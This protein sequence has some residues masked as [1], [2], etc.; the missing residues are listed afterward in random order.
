VR[1]KLLGAAIAALFTSENASAAM[2]VEYAFTGTGTAD[3]RDQRQAGD[4]FTR[5]N[6][7]FIGRILVDLSTSSQLL[8][9]GLSYGPEEVSGGVDANS[10]F[11]NYA[12]S[13]HH[14]SA[15][16]S[17]NLD[18]APGT[19]NGSFPTSSSGFLG[20]RVSG[21]IDDYLTGFQNGSGVIKSLQVINFGDAYPGGLDQPSFYMSISTAAVPEP[22]TWAMMLLGF[23]AVGYSMRRS[24]KVTY[25]HA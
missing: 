5:M 18:F 10:M 20:G 14:F 24:Q 19:L 21:N 17:V 22:A 7:D 6:V 25:S 23:G 13:M 16:Y 1:L 2:I 8:D 3:Y 12:A 9:A 15:R 4:P 11:A